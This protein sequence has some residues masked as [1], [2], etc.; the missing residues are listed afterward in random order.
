MQKCTRFRPLL[1]RIGEVYQNK[2][3]FCCKCKHF[4]SVMSCASYNKWMANCLKRPIFRLN[5]GQPET[6]YG[7]A[8]FR[9]LLLQ[10]TAQT[11][12]PTLKL[13]STLWRITQVTLSHKP[14][15][16]AKYD[17][18][19][20]SDACFATG[21]A[22]YNPPQDK[23]NKTEEYKTL[24]GDMSEP[25][26]IMLNEFIQTQCAASGVRHRELVFQTTCIP[27]YTLVYSLNV[28]TPLTMSFQVIAS[29]GSTQQDITKISD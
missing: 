10:I 6:G 16:L 4:S 28:F 17:K 7:F 26:G 14:I 12:L 19:H 13:S 20:H 8:L 18:K 25:L 2:R 29:S 21:R 5:T 15:E 24:S 22:L 11:L 9:L 1:Y 3:S 23:E 27:L